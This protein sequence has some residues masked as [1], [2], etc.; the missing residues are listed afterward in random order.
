MQSICFRID[1]SSQIVFGKTLLYIQHFCIGAAA[2]NLKGSQLLWSIANAQV[3]NPSS[4]QVL[5]S[6]WTCA[7]PSS[8]SSTLH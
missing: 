1:S 4:S 3:R 7:D 2:R 6:F 5:L 8:S